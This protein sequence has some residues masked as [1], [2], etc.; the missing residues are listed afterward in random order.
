VNGGGGITG[1][2]PQVTTPG[3]GYAVASAVATTGGTGSNAHVNITAVQPA[4]TS[5]L[6][7]LFY[8]AA[9]GLTYN[10]VV[11]AV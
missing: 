10:V 3:T 2:N 8:E 5:D 4:G 9:Q 7:L 11:A 1:I 6:S